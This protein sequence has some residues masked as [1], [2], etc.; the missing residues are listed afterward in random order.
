[1]PKRSREN[2]DPLCENALS[3][4][5]LEN[6]LKNKSYKCLGLPNFLVRTPS[7]SNE[8]WFSFSRHW[9]PIGLVDSNGKTVISK[10]PIHLEIIP[11]DKHL[12][13]TKITTAA[14]K[15]IYWFSVIDPHSIG[16]VTL[17]FTS[18][19]TDPFIHQIQILKDAPLL[20]SV[21]STTK[22]TLVSKKEMKETPKQ[23]VKVTK[24]DSKNE[25]ID[26]ESKRIRTN[27]SNPIVQVKQDIKLK[28][29]PVIKTSS[30]SSGRSGGI[31]GTSSPIPGGGP[32]LPSK[33][34]IERSAFTRPPTTN[35]EMLTKVSITDIVRVRGPMLIIALP[36]SLTVALLDD[37]ARVDSEALAVTKLESTFKIPDKSLSMLHISVTEL[38]NRIQ[39]RAKHSI[40][41]ADILIVRLRQLFECLF[42]STILYSSERTAM[43]QQLVSLRAQKR[44][45]A[46]SFGGIYLLRLLVLIV[47]GADSIYPPTTEGVNEEAEELSGSALTQD[48]PLNREE[49][50]SSDMSNALEKLAEENVLSNKK[51]SS[52]RLTSSSNFS[53]SKLRKTALMSKHHEKEFYKLQEVIDCALKELDETAHFVF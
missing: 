51:S 45:Y 27:S 48:Y 3:I 4:K 28:L 2:D 5:V 10:N 15:G 9:H 30:T 20:P 13:T 39:V 32:R 6:E 23:V 47:T 8:P 18:P 25:N 11:A 42:E 17:K 7:E 49:R 40:N 43:K 24:E 26:V 53:H 46:D 33:F 22:S 19:G 35:D 37:R 12:D 16:Y 52:P 41:E 29:H 44:N 21:V 34:R 31:G 38:L 50:S 14:K 36:S 1:M